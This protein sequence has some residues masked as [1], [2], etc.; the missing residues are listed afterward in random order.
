MSNQQLASIDGGF[1]LEQII[2]GSRL[3][4]T[5]T[6]KVRSCCS[7]WRECEKDDVYVAIVGDDFDGHDFAQ[8]AISRGATAVVAER[9]LA[10]NCP[11][12]LVPDSRKAFG[13]ICH[14][15]AGT[16][17]DQISTVGIAG[18]D[19]KTVT[20]HLI[21]SIYRAAGSRVGLIS[22]IEV[23]TG[24]CEAPANGTELNAPLLADRLGQM[25]LSGCNHAVVEMPSIALAQ[26]ASSGVRLDA[27]VLTNIRRDFRDFHGNDGNYI[28]AHQRLLEYLKPTG[29]AVLNADDPTTHYLLDQIDTPTLTIGIR[30]AAEIKA[31]IVERTSTDQT[32]LLQAG[33]DSVAVR[34]SIIGDQHVYNCLSA[35]A[36]AL[37]TGVPLTTIADGLEAAGA[38]PGR[39]ERVECGQEFGVWIDAASSPSQLATA[40]N[41]VRKVTRGKVYCVCSVTGDQTD[42]HRKRMGEIIER[43]ADQAVITKAAIRE[44]VDYEPF[45]QVLDGF[46]KPAGAEVIPNRFNAI[47]WALSRAGAGDAVLVA[48]SGERSIGSVGEK[49]WPISDRDVCQA[50][51]YDRVKPE[52][53]QPG[54]DIYKIDDYR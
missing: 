30:Q 25:V 29:F 15:L 32:F 50:W 41:A 13:S 40:I 46:T 7:S 24:R 44:H 51:L 52:S 12:C 42:G 31:K 14:A 4:G 22:S 21:R 28:R 35:T 26:H 53:Q 2:P 48:G 34:T 19:G 8:E 33:S 38:I 11:Q 10:I 3:I 39:M 23:N 43:A 45:H 6:I 16:P 5:Q 27:A 54:Q 37:T 9:L 1:R 49:C 20:A 47:E 18:S 17:S 36:V